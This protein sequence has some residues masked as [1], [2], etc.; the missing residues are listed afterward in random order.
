MIV[1]ALYHTNGTVSIVYPAIKSKRENETEKE[2]LHRV[3]TKSNPNGLPYEDFDLEK[4][5]L[6]DSR[7]RNAWVKGR[8]GI[9]I[10]LDK[11]KAQVLDEVRAV[12][13][14]ELERTDIIITRALET[15]E[16]IKINETKK[17]RERLRDLPQT[18]RIDKIKTVDELLAVY[19]KVLTIEDYLALA[20]G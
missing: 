13:N 11:A 1:R 3:F 12:R 16:V 8:N 18:I 19:P 20:E 15:G 9:E 2:W 6:P 14:K 7:F 17:Y 4:T 5:T 10:D